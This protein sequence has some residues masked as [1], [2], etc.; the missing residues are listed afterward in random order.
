L[1]RDLGNWLLAQLPWTSD[2]L[3]EAVA[4]GRD[5]EFYEFYLQSDLQWELFPEAR[6]LGFRRVPYSFETGVE[7]DGTF[8]P[9]GAVRSPDGLILAEYDLGQSVEFEAELPDVSEVEDGWK[10]SEPNF[11]GHIIV[12]G[13]V[14]MIV[15][16]AVL[17]EYP[18]GLAVD[19]L[20]W[21]RIDGP[22]PGAAPLDPIPGQLSLFGSDQTNEATAPSDDRS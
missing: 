19:Q 7:W 16:L 20:S 13:Q 14:Q 15:R 6:D 5:Q 11:L 18:G 2:S 22:A 21:R 4:R 3:E 8:V 17:F 1:V 9:Q 12:R 10:V